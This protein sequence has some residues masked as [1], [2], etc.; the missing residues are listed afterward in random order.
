M[1]SALYG[2]IGVV[3]GF[4]LTWLK[5]LYS[6][7]TKNKK[8]AE[9]LCIQ[10]TSMLDRFISACLNVVCDDGQPDE[11]GYYRTQVATPVLEPE[12]LEVNWKSLSTDLLYE[13]LSFPLQI[14]NA[15]ASIHSTFEFVASPPEYSEVFEERKFQY[16]KLGI[17]ASKLAGRL[18]QYSRLPEKEIED[19]DP[20]QR[21]HQ[22]IKEVEELRK[23]R[24]QQQEK[25]LQELSK[26]GDKT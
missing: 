26:L 1:E 12:K 17:K 8:D 21:M 15:E 22:M 25:M 23:T 2:L 11:T 3:L 24:N 4:A 7:R 13:V 6:Q 14:E 9:Y 10:V 19:W 16:A 5:D 20:T 18:R